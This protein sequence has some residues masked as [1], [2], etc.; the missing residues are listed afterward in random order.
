M[1]VTNDDLLNAMENSFFVFPDV[2]GKIQHV[3]F[4]GVRG[5]WSPVSKSFHANAVG[6]V[7]LNVENV[8]SGIQQVH[9]YFSNRDCS[10]QWFFAPSLATPATLGERL[11]AAGISKAGEAAGSY[12]ID[13]DIAVTSNPA[14]Q[15]R[16][17]IDDAGRQD[18]IDTFTQGF[19]IPEDTADI[20]LD[21][22]NSV[23]ARK[24]VAYL[25]NQPISAAVMFYMPGVPIAMFQGAATLKE[26]R[27]K[28]AYSALLKQR[29]QDA[30]ADGMEAAVLQADRSS[31]APIC[32]KYGFKELTGIVFHVWQPDDAAY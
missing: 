26:Y 22:M 27:G 6:N 25:D 7:R 5:M 8:D 15:V 10:Y 1:A 11:E 14:I 13:F 28:R 16:E 30:K 9:E 29:L 3:E 18:L 32:A 20:M 31:S 21:M 19:P 24:Y 4:E 23:N 12:L 2:Q 17:I